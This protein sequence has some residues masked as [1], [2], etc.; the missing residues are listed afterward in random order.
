MENFSGKDNICIKAQCLKLMLLLNAKE[1][2]IEDAVYALSCVD[3]IDK[4]GNRVKG[5]RAN[6]PLLFNKKYVRLSLNALYNSKLILLNGP[7]LELSY[8]GEMFI[9]SLMCQDCRDVSEYLK[10]VDFVVK[11]DARMLY[12]ELLNKG[13]LYDNR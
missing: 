1:Y 3:M 2:K 8:V 12:L 10:K 13:E 9:K 5:Y 6:N 11:A 7:L 4:N